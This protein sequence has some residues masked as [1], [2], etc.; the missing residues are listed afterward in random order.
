MSQLSETLPDGGGANSHLQPSK[1]VVGRLE[2]LAVW[3]GCGG[4][5]GGLAD[6]RPGIGSKGGRD[7][8]YPWGWGEQAG[9]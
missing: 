9:Q 5:A 6:G 1:A 2:P 3:W 8:V 4:D 7:T